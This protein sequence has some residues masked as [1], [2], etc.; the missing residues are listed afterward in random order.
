VADTARRRTLVDVLSYNVD[1]DVAGD[2][3][4]F[5]S[6]TEIRFR[7]HQPGAASV[8]DLDAAAIRRVVL[9]GEDLEPSAAWH[10]GQLWLPGLAAEN[11]LTVEASLP[12]A[13][14]GAAGL[15]RRTWPDGGGCV[16]S[17]PLP[18]GGRHIFCCFYQEDLRAPVTMSV[19][20][21]A[22]WSCFANG[23]AVS[24]R[25]S[26][27]PNRWNF[28]TTAPIA[29]YAVSC[30]AGPFTS[31]ALRVDSQL[32][33][34]VHARPT[35]A[36]LLAGLV[37]PDVIGQPLRYYE[38]GF[39]ATYPSAKCDVVFVPGY[40]PLAFGAPGLVIVQERVLDQASVDKSGLYLA[41]VLAH[42]LAH[43]WLGGLIDTRA[44]EAEGLIEGLATY[45]SRCFL[46]DTRP[47]PGPWDPALSRTLPDDGYASYAL[48]FRRLERS[49][50]KQA[51]LDGASMLIREHRNQCITRAD[52]AGCLSRASGHN[53]R[54][55]DLD[56]A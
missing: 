36:T 56:P 7:C 42:E 55:S 18:D 31:R 9:N 44:H 25:A 29:P 49:I 26:T 11:V 46:A 40:P 21:P 5:S 43:A 54:A 30:C 50:G 8:A 41:L 16:F 53:V 45:V 15:H 12:Y 19:T 23:R 52:L 38:S 39:G 51:V 6:R 10:D 20:A 1:L 2:T 37:G 32:P 3:D 34:A 47:A 27:Q 48:P 28:A 33:V 35:A 14:A 22:G 24:V 13:S 17:K 4:S